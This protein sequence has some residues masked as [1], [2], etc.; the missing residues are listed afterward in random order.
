MKIQDA[1]KNRENNFTLLRLLAALAVMYGHSY[2]LS[3]GTAGGE[4]PI[5][6][7][8]IRYWGK[9]L[10]ALAVDLFFVTSGF[11]V[12][13]SYVQR[14]NLFA[15]VEARMLRI[16]PGLI[17]AVLFCVFIVGVFVTTE[18]AAN[19]FSSPSTWSYLKHNAVLVTQLGY[20]CMGM[21]S[22]LDFVHHDAVA[23]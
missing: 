22:L 3:L 23:S 8:L 21:E 11:L 6:N 1:L 10:P 17:V 14:N 16:Y 19:Y 18:S 20:A 12:T 7:L 2:V 4:D 5:S 15:F 13:A 9:S